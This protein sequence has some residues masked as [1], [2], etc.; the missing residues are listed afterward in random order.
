MAGVGGAAVGSAVGIGVEN[1]EV[2]VSRGEGWAVSEAAV[3][4]MLDIPS[5][6]TWAP[7]GVGVTLG[8]K[9][10]VHPVKR[11]AIVKRPSDVVSRCVLFMLASP[12]CSNSQ[13]AATVSW[14]H[15]GQ[16]TSNRANG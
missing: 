10:N 11:K 7:E 4:A 16:T 15:N 12:P 8:A 13:T 1:S 3:V 6:T 14:Y 9:G 2:G 5:A